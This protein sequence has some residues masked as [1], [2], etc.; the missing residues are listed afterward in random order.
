MDV[1]QCQRNAQALWCLELRR[2]NLLQEGQHNRL[3]T[4]TY[5]QLAAFPVMRAHIGGQLHASKRTRG[6]R[7]SSNHQSVKQKQSWSAERTYGCPQP[8]PPPKQQHRCGVPGTH[9]FRPTGWRTAGVPPPHCA[10][11]VPARASAADRQPMTLHSKQ[12]HPSILRRTCCA[13]STPFSVLVASCTAPHHAQD[14]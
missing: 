6:G 3:W 1:L 10:A 8:V 9:S 7:K 11:A 12:S 5:A 14:V 13:I 4:D 2:V